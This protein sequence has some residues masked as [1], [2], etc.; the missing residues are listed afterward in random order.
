[1]TRDRRD[2][3]TAGLPDGAY[4]AL[5]RGLSASRLWSLLMDVLE[6]RAAART[7]PAIAEQWASDRFVQ[8]GVVDQRTHVD[9]DRHLIAAAVASAFES[10]E[11]SPIAPLGV[12][13]LMGRASQNKVLSA[14]RGT[15][16]VA[17]PTNVLALECAR[18]L[19]RKPSTPVRLATSH[20]CVR[21]QEVPKQ[22]GFTATFR[23]FCLA[24]AGIEQENHAFVVEAVTGQIKAMLNALERL[25]QDGFAFSERKVLLFTTEPR[26]AI[27]DRIADTLA[28]STIVRALLEHPY[29]TNGVRFQVAVRTKDGAEIPFIDGGVFDW[30]A[31][32]TSNRRAVYVASGM[33]S[34]LV[35]L[36]FRA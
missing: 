20:R 21:T 5:A 10:I 17:D 14:L 12:C 33:G 35:P 8:P 24:S 32:L 31:K 36:L 13:S 30:V 9:V 23:I 18:R 27:G 3:I 22:S 19:R 15:E 4:D 6:A 25:E 7:L 26:S 11:L 16:V 2:W 34:Q 29:Y 1:M 28:G